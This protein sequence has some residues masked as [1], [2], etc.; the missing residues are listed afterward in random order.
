MEYVRICGIKAKDLPV[1]SCPKCQTDL[2]IIPTILR[3]HRYG[4]FFVCPICDG[5]TAYS[6]YFVPD[7]FLK[8]IPE[9][10]SSEAP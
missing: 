8:Y 7:A 1:A 5:K 3:R 10:D 9:V 2:H 4:F 6:S